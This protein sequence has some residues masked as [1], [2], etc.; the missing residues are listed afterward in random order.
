MAFVFES[1]RPACRSLYL[2]EAFRD[3]Q[4]Y[5]RNR[6]CRIGRVYPELGVRVFTRTFME[7]DIINGISIPEEL[8]NAA[9]R[10][11]AELE[12]RFPDL[13]AGFEEK[14]S[15]KIVR[16]KRLGSPIFSASDI[17]YMT[18]KS[19]GLCELVRKYDEERELIKKVTESIKELGD[20]ICA[21]GFF[22]GTG[23]Y[24]IES[25][26]NFMDN[27]E[28]LCE[29]LSPKILEKI[30]E[31]KWTDGISEFYI[32]FGK[33]LADD[34]HTLFFLEDP[35]EGEGRD[36]F[37]ISTG[38]YEGKPFPRIDIWEKNFLSVGES[39]K[40]AKHFHLGAGKYRKSPNRVIR[41]VFGDSPEESFSMVA[42][43]S[44]PGLSPQEIFG[45]F[46]KRRMVVE[47]PPE[48]QFVKDALKR[49]K[50][51]TGDDLSY[52]R[53]G[54]L[55]GMLLREE[56]P[57]KGEDTLILYVDKLFLKGPEDVKNGEKHQS[58]RAIVA[59]PSYTFE[60][61]RKAIEYRNH[62]EELFIITKER[63][64]C[65]KNLPKV[66]KLREITSFL[67]FLAMYF[68]GGLFLHSYGFPSLRFKGFDSVME[69]MRKMLRYNV[70]GAVFTNGLS[71]FQKEILR[72][73]GYKE[74]ELETLDTTVVI[75][76]WKIFPERK[77]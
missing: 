52:Q 9:I 12:Q 36:I 59:D 58:Y 51:E 20:E 28:S 5:P 27:T 72:A 6:R 70:G 73:F 38:K 44:E 8:K 3:L 55:K 50:E 24:G 49:K 53:K 14:E 45:Y 43:L 2:G 71:H 54:L 15:S 25:I 46:R 40:T 77:A 32:S 21:L 39:S 30:A 41:G 13:L 61:A 33:A 1:G 16:N 76:D 7:S 4:G 23:E 66:V 75:T 37:G 63:L 22:L 64:L 74:K 69:E 17:R 31:G 62:L 19:C 56:I 26:G 35:E 68:S 10:E 42:K 60:A 34:R 47:I 67:M 48:T 11:M 65:L 18:V 29:D 57:L